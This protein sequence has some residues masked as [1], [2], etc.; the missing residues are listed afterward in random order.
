[1][2]I[3]GTTSSTASVDQIMSAT[4]LSSQA[5]SSASSGTGGAAASSADKAY[6][7]FLLMLTTQLQHQDPL[8]PTNTDQ[9]TSEM[10]QLSSLEQQL[11]TN[12][13]LTSMASNLSSITAA[14]G[15]GYI[16]KKIETTGDT[17]P[18]QNGT[19]NWNYTLDQNASNVSLKV[20][21]SK[22]S[23]VWSGSGD[24]AAGSHAFSWNGVDNAGNT[25]TTG[26]YTLKVVATDTSG[27]AVTSTTSFTGTVTGIDTSGGNTQLQVGDI[28]VPLANVT[29]LT[30]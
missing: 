12:N 1:M 10:I 21:D 15:L 16:G 6:N 22:G 3:T 19:A 24:G 20:V 27:N 25:H 8:N 7:T 14:N 4:T 28:T 29:T 13:Q 18:L 5:A 11:A 23:T 9:F 17:T 30:N 2:S 26:D